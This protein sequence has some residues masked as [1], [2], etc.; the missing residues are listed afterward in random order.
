MN[1]VIG[2]VAVALFVLM[3]TGSVTQ[4][5]DRLLRKLGIHMRDLSLLVAPAALLAGALDAPYIASAHPQ[6]AFY[7]AVLFAGFALCSAPAIVNRRLERFERDLFFKGVRT[8][9]EKQARKRLLYIMPYLISPIALGVFFRVLF[10]RGKLVSVKQHQQRK[11]RRRQMVR[12]D[13]FD[14]LDAF[15]SFNVNPA[16]GLP[17]IGYRD[18]AG[19]RYGTFDNED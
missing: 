12:D 17:M 4:G 18:V 6:A 2:F 7:F 9:D 3:I 5:L 14:T 8:L 1:T 19:N 10:S 13:T 11:V 16:T 15:D